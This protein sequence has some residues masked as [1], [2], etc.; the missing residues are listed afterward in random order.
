MSH[1]SKKPQTRKS[2]DYAVRRCIAADSIGG[3]DQA[4]AALARRLEALFEQRDE[5]IEL[6]AE[7]YVAAGSLLIDLDAVDTEHGTKLLDNLSE[8]R[9]KHK[10]VVP[11]PSYKKVVKS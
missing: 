3:F 1:R 9:L 4:R 5:L 2:I 8:A 7:A 10:D 11:F 6:A